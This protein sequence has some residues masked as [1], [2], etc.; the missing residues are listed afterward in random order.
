MNVNETPYSQGWRNNW[1]NSDI[2]SSSNILLYSYFNLNILSQKHARSW[3]IQFT[4][5][6]ILTCSKTFTVNF[7]VWQLCIACRQVCTRVMSAGNATINT[8][9][10]CHSYKAINHIYVQRY[11]LFTFWKCKTMIFLPCYTYFAVIIT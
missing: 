1:R 10:I 3:D 4:F 6:L 5:T 11:H 2:Y 8:S 7:T 9:Y